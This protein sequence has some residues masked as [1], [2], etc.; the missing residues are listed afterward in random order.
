[1]DLVVGT[2]K[3]KLFYPEWNTDNVLTLGESKTFTGNFRFP[4]SEKTC[5]S[6][7]SGDII[8]D[9]F[10][11]DPNSIEKEAEP[12]QDY[13]IIKIKRIVYDPPGAD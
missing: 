6:L 5:V 13:P 12:K 3:T 7:I 8:F 2:R 10:C 4:N 1:M 9:S 11:Y